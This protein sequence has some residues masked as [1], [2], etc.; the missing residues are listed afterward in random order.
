MS[1]ASGLVALLSIPTLILWPAFSFAQ[2]HALTVR[3]VI[4]MQTFID[5]NPFPAESYPATEVQ[6]SPDKRSFAVVAQRGLIAANEL[7]STIWVF[8]TRAVSRSRTASIETE[9][10]KPKAVVRMSA[11][12]NDSAVTQMRWVN[13]GELAFLGR[14]KTSERSLFIVDAHSGALK[15]ITPN[16]QDVTT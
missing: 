9:M 1:S 15:K 4:E 5:P 6:Y 10:P 2:W 13:S 14:D 8:D 3:D 11:V 12:A 16:E 7:E